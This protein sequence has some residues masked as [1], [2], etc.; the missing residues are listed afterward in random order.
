MA[1]FQSASS[2]STIASRIMRND[3]PKRNNPR[4]VILYVCIST[5]DA[6]VDISYSLD[7]WSR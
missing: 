5:T 4:H 2:P 6:D 1:V 3:K 7:L